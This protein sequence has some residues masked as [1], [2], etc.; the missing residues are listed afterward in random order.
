VVQLTEWQADGGVIQ[1]SSPQWG[2]GADG[3]GFNVAWWSTSTDWTYDS[4]LQYSLGRV[5]TTPVELRHGIVSPRLLMYAQRVTD[6]PVNV[7]AL[8]MSVSTLTLPAPSGAPPV[9]G[10]GLADLLAVAPHL[11]AD[12]VL[13]IDAAGTV[14]VEWEPGSTPAP[15]GGTN[16]TGLVLSVFTESTLGATAGH[17]TDTGPIPVSVRAMPW[18]GTGS[19]TLPPR[20]A[21]VEVA[22]LSVPHAPGNQQFELGSFE[23]P[24]G[25]SAATFSIWGPTTT[26]PNTYI[27]A[28]VFAESV[29]TEYT[30]PRYR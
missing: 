9:L 16:V 14:F 23:I 30:A 26:A 1:P 5:T 21:W 7:V 11:T 15:S 6:E 27:D 4:A 2:R 24:E 25:W 17:T 28:R 20:E 3:L 22:S 29:G 18:P 19:A 8:N 10:T 12:D 13:P